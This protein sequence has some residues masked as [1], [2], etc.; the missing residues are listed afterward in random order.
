ML[1][2]EE[3]DRETL[4]YAAKLFAIVNRISA[5]TLD[6]ERVSVLRF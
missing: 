3:V 6:G 4:A 5:L 1:R 2:T